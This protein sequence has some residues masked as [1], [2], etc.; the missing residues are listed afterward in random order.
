MTF[1]GTTGATTGEEADFLAAVTEGAEAALGTNLKTCC[2]S[3]LMPFAG[4]FPF[5]VIT[6]SSFVTIASPERWVL[7][8]RGRPLLRVSPL[9]VLGVIV[10]S[11][12]SPA[13]IPLFKDIT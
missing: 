8:R 2:D 9:D 13:A 7:L 12:S 6:V 10:T 4:S 1:V 11:F 5:F 3:T